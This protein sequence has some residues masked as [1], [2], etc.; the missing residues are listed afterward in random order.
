[1]V[2]AIATGDV[3]G[4]RNAIT[5]MTLAMKT[6]PWGFIISAVVAVAAAYV[7]FSDE[8]KA[9]ETAQSMM[10]KTIKETEQIVNQ[11][12]ASFKLLIAIAKDKTASIEAQTNALNKAKEIGGEYTKGLT[13]QNIA[14]AEGTKL[15][16]AYVKSLEKKAMLEV[17]QKRQKSIMEDMDKKKNMSLEEE[18]HWYDE[19]I[20]MVTNL[21]NAQNAAAD[22]AVNASLRKQKGLDNLQSQLNLTNTE[23]EAFL[24]K[25]PSLIVDIETNTTGGGSGFTPPPGGGGTGAGTKKNPNASLAEINKLKLDEQAKFNEQTLKL[26]RQIEDDKI[27]AMQDGYAKEVQIENLRYQREIEDLNRQKVH[28][29]ELAKL[30]DDIAKAKEAKDTTKYNALL[31]IRKGWDAKNLELD[32]KIDTIKEGK[33]LIHNNKV[34][35]IKEKSAKDLLEKQLQDFEQ[36]KQS[37]ETDFNNE[38]AGMERTTPVNPAITV[39]AK[40]W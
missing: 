18:I 37:R 38:L 31:A 16:D 26:S 23:M 7:V 20:A 17:L 12:T 39:T 6:T 10:N 30:D 25:N 33:L 34:A 36:E 29:D 8:A 1:M 35:L 22:V 9:A 15:I 13:L 32:S 19:A 40:A 27:A 24:K 2:V 5:A 28:T 3:I 11:Q 21:G 4:L 14:T